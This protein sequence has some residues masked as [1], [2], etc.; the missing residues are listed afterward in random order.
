MRS[1]RRARTLAVLSLTAAAAAL[2]GDLWKGSAALWEAAALGT[3]GMA[4]L[5]SAVWYVVR[6]LTPSTVRR[7][8]RLASKI[9]M[10]SLLAG[11]SVEILLI[12]NSGS[13]RVDAVAA[14]VLIIA[15]HGAT[16]AVP[17]QRE[18]ALR[19]GSSR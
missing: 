10:T 14:L 7:Y 18:V 13:L 8:V 17:A 1:M 19:R 15:V 2:A 4:C 12:S 9:W 6:G 5:G 11:M 3:L 16:I